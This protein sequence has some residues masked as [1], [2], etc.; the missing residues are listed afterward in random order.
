M[1]PGEAAMRYAG[2]LGWPVYPRP[3]GRF[4]KNSQ[5][6][7][8]ATR[9]PAKIARWWQQY[10]DALI[11]M[12]TG[13]VSG[14]VVL[15]ID[16]KN[17]KD[18]YEVLERLGK[19][20]LPDTPM[21]HTPNHGVHVYFAV[22]PTTPIRVATGKYSGLGEGLDVL[23]DGGSVALPTPGWG[24]RWDPHL[25][26]GTTPLF[27]APAW[28]ARR[29]PTQRHGDS[30]AL[31]PRQLLQAA[32][33]R[34][35]SAGNG[36]RHATLNREAFLVGCI[37]ARGQLDHGLARHELEA[38]AVALMAADFNGRQAGYDLD[39]AFRDGLRKGGQPR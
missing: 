5:G 29:K 23:G 38:A 31:D 1:T 3:Q 27:V 2:K 12:P 26:P 22:N 18:G 16:R 13:A 39:H 10:P 17:G 28:L 21:A 32:C 15:D 19:A 25:H 8:D 37:C 33:E 36:T 7:K 24:Y 30:R 11:G 6:W 14:V 9:D 35:R 4:I 34:I 20:Q